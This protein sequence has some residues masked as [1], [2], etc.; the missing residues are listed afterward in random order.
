MSTFAGVLM[1]LV[2]TGVIDVGMSHQ[3][4]V[5]FNT[6]MSVLVALGVVSDP[7]SHIKGDQNV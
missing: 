3:V 2:N 7:D 1:I 5:V 4:E 6:V